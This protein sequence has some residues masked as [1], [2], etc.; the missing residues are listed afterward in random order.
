VVVHPLLERIFHVLDSEGRIHVDLAS[1]GD[2][3]ANLNVA[4]A[5]IVASLLANFQ[6]NRK[7]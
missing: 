2:L 4:K 6:F 7:D 3:L 1:F 5:I